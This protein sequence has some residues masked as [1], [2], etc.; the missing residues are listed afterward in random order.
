MFEEKKNCYGNSAKNFVRVIVDSDTGVMYLSNKHS[1]ILMKSVD[2]LPS[3]FS[4]RTKI[5]NHV[6]E[7]SKLS[8]FV[9]W[10]NIF[11]NEDDGT[12]YIGGDEIL[13]QCVDQFGMPK[14]Y[15]K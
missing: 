9:G 12:M 5:V 1:M 10:Q 15:N 8:Q 7:I 6:H 13:V 3:I 11:V 4:E 14:I 2:G